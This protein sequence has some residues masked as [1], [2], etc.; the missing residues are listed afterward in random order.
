LA[1]L[2]GQS[3]KDFVKY[4]FTTAPSNN[5][6]WWFQLD[7]QGGVNS[8]TA[9]A[10]TSLTSYAHRDKLYIIQFYDRTFFGDYPSN[11]FDFLD[12]WVKN[13]TSSL[14]ENDWGMYIN[15]ADARLDRD[16]A[17]KAYW[18]KSLPQLQKVKAKYDPDEL[19]YYPISIKPSA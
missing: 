6:I 4:W 9:T 16:A 17:Q 19:F 18:R 2:K 1:G 8:F 15:Y 12:Y 11:G 10:D 5:R 14:T 7:L 3:A 13:T